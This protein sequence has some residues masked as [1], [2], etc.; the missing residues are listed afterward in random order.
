[1]AEQTD[2]ASGPVQFMQQLVAL[3]YRV[4]ASPLQQRFDAGMRE[5]RITG[6]K[7]PVCSRV[8]VPPKGYCPLDT[9]ITTE[10][11]EVEVADAGIVTSFTV[12]TPIQYRGQ[13]ERQP[14]ALAS[15]LLDGASSTVGQ[16]RIAGAPDDVR[17]GMRVKAL[18]KPKEERVGEASA[19]A[20]GI[21]RAIEHWDAT[22]E[23]DAPR[24][25]FAE[26]IL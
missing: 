18:W 6:H 19:M 22:G 11:H 12:L 4:L 23:P 26:H 10:E 16:Q 20:W 9:V 3:D 17:A 21:G 14:Y 5:G 25:A 13:K 24:D 15:L 2:A 8:F 7:C 1:M